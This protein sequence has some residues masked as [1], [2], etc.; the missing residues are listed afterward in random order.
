MNKIIKY[1]ILITM[2]IGI[3]VRAQ[4]TEYLVKSAF[5]EKILSVYR[6][7]KRKTIA[8]L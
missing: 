5:I 6:M 4:D 7:A 3:G 8:K 2:V 1:L